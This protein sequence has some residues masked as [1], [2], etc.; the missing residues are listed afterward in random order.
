MRDGFLRREDRAW[1]HTAQ[2]ALWSLLPYWPK[3]K[4]LPS[5]DKFLGRT[6]HL[7][8]ETKKD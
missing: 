3:R 6:L 4:R 7:M 1:H 5:V 2:H 8:P